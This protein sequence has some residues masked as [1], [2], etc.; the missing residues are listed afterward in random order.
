MEEWAKQA[1]WTLT[2]L[3]CN[4][5]SWISNNANFQTLINIWLTEINN[6]VL[7][8]LK[9]DQ[10]THNNNVYGTNSL[11][12]QCIIFNAKFQHLIV[13]LWCIALAMCIKARKKIGINMKELSY[14]PHVEILI[15]HT[16]HKDKQ[17]IIGP[18]QSM[19]RF[20]ESAEQS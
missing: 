1:Q 14:I 10:R 18:F 13:I 7:Q 4:H 11:F 16:I 5:Q 15:S 3:K 6:Q 19:E 20:K 17:N 8:I 9:E 12:K 2:L